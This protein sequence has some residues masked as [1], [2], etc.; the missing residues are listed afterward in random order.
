[1]TKLS[2]YGDRYSDICL[3]IPESVSF[4]DFLLRWNFFFHL[5]DYLQEPGAN[6][7]DHII[8]EVIAAQFNP[9]SSEGKS[10]KRRNGNGRTSSPK[11]IRNDSKRSDIS[12][13]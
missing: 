9:S 11:R 8:D 2:F 3:E 5:S 4:V 7:H 6:I 10:S 1:M 12:V 13:R